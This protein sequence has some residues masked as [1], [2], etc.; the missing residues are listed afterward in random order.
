[1]DK[2]LDNTTAL[3]APKSARTRYL[4]ECQALILRRVLSGAEASSEDIWPVLPVPDGLDAR[5]LGDVFSG[6]LADGMIKPAKFIRSSR[7]CR[8]KGLLRTWRLLDR[9]KAKAY[10]DALKRSGDC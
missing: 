9:R 10:L 5:I 6:L 4:R 3:C 1:M 2:R 7:P 8:H